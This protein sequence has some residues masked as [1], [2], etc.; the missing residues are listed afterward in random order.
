MTCYWNC[1]ARTC[2]MLEETFWRI[3]ETDYLIKSG[4]SNNILFS[5]AREFPRTSYNHRTMLKNYDEKAAASIESNLVSSLMRA[6]CALRHLQKDF[7]FTW[8][9]LCKNSFI[10]CQTK[11]P[12][13]D[14]F[15]PNAI[16]IKFNFSRHHQFNSRS[17]KTKCWSIAIFN[18]ATV[19]LAISE[20]KFYFSFIKF[21]LKAWMN[22]EQ[23]SGQWWTLGNKFSIK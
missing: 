4:K 7:F 14:C 10:R 15:P 20:T 13:F 22:I 2:I 11:C 8:W 17:F 9:E 19:L 1:N 5:I 18:I 23:W 3:N 12:K 6:E 16:K 21:N